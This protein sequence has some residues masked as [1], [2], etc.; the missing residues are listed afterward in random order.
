MNTPFDTLLFENIDAIFENLRKRIDV[1]QKKRFLVRID[2]IQHY[3]ANTK[4]IKY[5]IDYYGV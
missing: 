2:E 5:L 4:I 1:N 3:P